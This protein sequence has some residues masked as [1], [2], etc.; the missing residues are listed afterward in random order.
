MFSYK[1]K[2]GNRVMVND[3]AAGLV[4]GLVGLI[5]YTGIVSRDSQSL[6]DGDYV[7]DVKLENG[8]TVTLRL[9]EECIDGTS[10]VHRNDVARCACCAMPILGQ[11]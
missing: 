10:E 9:P 3:N 1:Y 5:G 2:P 6:Y 8:A 7:V 11:P 4:A